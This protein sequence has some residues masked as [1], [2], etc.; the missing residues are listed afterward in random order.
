[1]PHLVASAKRFGDAVRFVGVS[2]ETDDLD[3]VRAAIAEHQVPYDQALADPELLAAFFGPE[4]DSAALP[5]TFVF[6][7]DGSLRRVFRRPVGAAELDALATS[8]AVGDAFIDG[9]LDRARAL[10]RTGELER[11]ATYLERIVEA[12]PDHAG[13]QLELGTLHALGGDHRRAE[14]AFQRAADLAP[15]DATARFRLG[16]ARMQ[17][18]RVTEAIA[19]LQAAVEVGGESGEVLLELGMAHAQIDRL[20]EARGLFTR[21]TVASPELAKAHALLGLTEAKLGDFDAA[22]A[23]FERALEIDPNEPLASVV[24]E[25]LDGK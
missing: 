19:P 1:M 24:I 11:A 17:Q 8:L 13:A 22:R 23:A 14:A 20:E 3:S 18:G 12:A 4:G 25:Q 21:A 16:V 7:P 10:M 15:T 5:S 6:A 9:M 2:V